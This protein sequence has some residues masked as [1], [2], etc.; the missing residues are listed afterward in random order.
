[1]TDY[2]TRRERELNSEDWLA[3][4][5]WEEHMH[6]LEQAEADKDRIEEEALLGEECQTCSGHEGC[7]DCM[8]EYD[9]WFDDC[10]VPIC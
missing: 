9:F 2:L 1:M 7:A 5:L 8:N 10:A 4:Y 3:H 6:A